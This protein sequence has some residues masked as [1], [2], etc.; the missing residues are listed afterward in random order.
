MKVNLNVKIAALVAFP[1]VL[2][3]FYSLASLKRNND[4]INMAN[5]MA[6]I[7]QAFKTN[8]EYIHSIQKERG[9]AA[10]FLAGKI[11]KAELEQQRDV[12]NKLRKDL[13]ARLKEIELKGKTDAALNSSD[14][15]LKSVRNSINDG[16]AIPAEATKKFTDSIAQLIQL[17]VVLSTHLI[18]E[19]LEVNLLSLTMFESGKESAGKLRANLTNALAANKP[20]AISQVSTLEAFRTGVLNNIDAPTL[21]VTPET[22]AKL[23]E[24][25]MTADWKQVL[26][27]FTAVLNKADQ[28]NYGIEPAV[29]FTAVTNSINNMGQIVLFEIEIVKGQIEVLRAEAQRTFWFTLAMMA[30]S[31]VVVLILSIYVIKNISTAINGAVIN[32]TTASESIASGSAEVATASNQ[33]SQGSTQSASALE[34]VVASLEEL[35]SLVNQNVKRAGSAATLSNESTESAELGQKEVEKLIMSMNDISTSSKKIEEIISVIDDIAF[36]TNLLALNAAVEAARA[37]EQGKGFAVVA[38]AVRSLAQRSAVAAKDISR[39]IRESVEQVEK[40]SKIA[41][42]SGVVLN[43]IVSS[44]KKVSLLSGEISIASN[45]QS[46]GLQQISKAMNDLDSSAQ[47]NAAASEEVSASA[48]NMNS[49]ADSITKLVESLKAVVNGGGSG[50]GTSKAA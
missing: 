37:G 35:N 44:I 19:G 48:E 47:R 14:D 31:L 46:Q 32:L 26:E 1:L 40:G 38:E 16:N 5:E 8:S 17:D 22:K 6:D 49:Q 12:V 27:I 28:G 23:N 20:L 24:F 29:F 43:N 10:M 11:T 33:V 3:L 7:G 45:E 36:Q 30:G 4:T 25:K 42:N 2:S 39:L 21:I 34:E 15:Y 50:D 13:D 41:D 9:V 18:F